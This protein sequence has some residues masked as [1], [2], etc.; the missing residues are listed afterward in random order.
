MPHIPG[1]EEDPPPSG[2][3]GGSITEGILGGVGAVITGN[4]LSDLATF[5]ENAANPIN[6]NLPSASASFSGGTLTSTLSPELQNLSGGFFESSQGFVDESNEFDRAGREEETLGLLR[7]RASGDENRQGNTLIN[8]LF[9][10]GRLG[11]TGGAQ[12][13]GDQA[14]GLA[15]A[16]LTRVLASRSEARTESEFLINQATASLKAGLA[17]EQPALDAAKLALEGGRNKAIVAGLAVNAQR[18]FNDFIASIFSGIIGGAGASGSTFFEDLFDLVFEGVDDIFTGG[19][20]GV[21]EEDPADPTEPGALPD[22][23]QGPPGGG[24][25]TLD[26]GGS[27]AFGGGNIFSSPAGTGSAGAV[28]AASGPIPLGSGGAIAAGA[29]D[30]G[31]GAAA[32]AGPAIGIA[33]VNAFVNG[34]K[35]NIANQEAGAD[36]HEALQDSGVGVQTSPAGIEGVPFI[37]SNTGRTVYASPVVLTQSARAFVVVDDGTGKPGMWTPTT[38]VITNAQLVEQQALRKEQISKTI[39]SG[40]FGDD[41]RAGLGSNPGGN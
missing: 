35:S 40:D 41:P 25:G 1:H 27:G 38:G 33:A 39:A 32:G 4:S 24:S 12:I 11:T 15:E 17:A 36:M 5:A 10:T 26:P 18:D 21:G 20:G 22:F 13:L 34:V 19:G 29:G 16:D 2:G 3:G 7:Q 9:G 28:D 37:D 14:R 30:V 6:V 8:K 23:G 31:G